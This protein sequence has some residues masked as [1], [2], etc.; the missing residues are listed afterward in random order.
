MK[1]IK[2][3]ALF[4]FVITFSCSESDDSNEE[5]QQLEQ[6][7]VSLAFTDGGGFVMENIVATVTSNY[8]NSN[9]LSILIKANAEDSGGILT[10][11]IVDNDASIEAFKFDDEYSYQNNVSS[12]YAT[13]T[14][15]D[16]SRDFSGTVGR[17]RITKYQENVNGNSK[18]TKIS[19]TFNITG[20][21]VTMLGNISGLVLNCEE[22]PNT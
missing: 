6:G 16:S 15:V 20:N 4:L 2:T 13:A 22:C 8:E 11:N 9:T 12:V 10:L 14:Y 3:L 5:K 1:T 19:A 7:S 17:V 21:F 18:A